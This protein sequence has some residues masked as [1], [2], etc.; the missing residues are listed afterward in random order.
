MDLKTVKRWEFFFKLADVGAGHLYEARTHGR[1]LGLRFDHQGDLIAADA[2]LGIYKVHMK[3]IDKKS[4]VLVPNT[5]SPGG[6]ILSLFNSV[7]IAK[8]GTVYYT[9]SN[10]YDLCDGILGVLGGPSQ[11]RMLKYDPSK[12]LSE[13]LMDD[14]FFANGIAMSEKEDFLVVNEL[15]FNKIW[16]YHLKGEKAGQRELLLKAP[17]FP[18]NLTPLGNGRFL[19][20]VLGVAEDEKNLLLD[21]MFKQPLLRKLAVRLLYAVT[22]IPRYLHTFFPLPIFEQISYYAANFETFKDQ[23]RN[24]T[25]LCNATRYSTL[26]VALTILI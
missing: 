10:N 8:D 25:H 9:S 5:A 3:D 4:E 13:V 11:G 12:K 22:R 24:S 20:G 15:G 23:G 7:A 17:G 21:V 14:M 2:Y 19:C 26:S 18:D 1:V 6:T 16:K